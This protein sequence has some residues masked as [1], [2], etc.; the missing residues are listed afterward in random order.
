[1]NVAI[2]GASSKPWRYSYKAMQLLEA[3]GHTV[4]IVNP[5]INSI[6]GRPAYK[7]LSV[8]KSTMDTLTVYVN[9][10]IST[11]IVEEIIRLK[12]RRV[13]F[14]PGAENPKIY[15]QLKKE[16]IEIEE[17]CTLVLLNTAKF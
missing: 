10:D 4:F 16:N 2:L 15:A 6:E 14:N 9:P 17:A 13:I 5:G 3:K 1:M 7:N 8:L 11:Q 12:P